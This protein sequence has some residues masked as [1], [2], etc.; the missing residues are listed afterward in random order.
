MLACA[1][2]FTCVHLSFIK[3]L[4]AITRNILSHATPILILASFRSLHL[5]SQESLMFWVELEQLEKLE[6]N[7]NTVNDAD[8]KV[9]MVLHH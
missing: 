2:N 4:R 9:K 5:I 1:Q 7:W 6:L 3:Y 8:A